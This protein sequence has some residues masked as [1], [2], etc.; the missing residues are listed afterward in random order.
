MPHCRRRTPSDQDSVT[1]GRLTRPS[2]TPVRLASRTFRIPTQAA[3]AACS[4]LRAQRRV[5]WRRYGGAATMKWYGGFSG[6]ERGIRTPEGLLTLTRFPG[7]RLKPLIHLSGS[8]I[9]PAAR[10]SPNSTR[11]AANR[12]RSRPFTHPHG[13]ASDGAPRA[14]GKTRSRCAHPSRPSRAPRSAAAPRQLPAC[15]RQPGGAARR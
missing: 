15:P 14:V 1:S 7:V 3:Q 8:A 9:L 4:S 11:S 2:A 6:G 12:H 10:T 13:E 5:R